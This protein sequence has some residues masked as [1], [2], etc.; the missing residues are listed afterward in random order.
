[1]LGGSAC[2]AVPPS[3]EVVTGKETPLSFSSNEK[4]VLKSGTKVL[5]PSSVATLS[6]GAKDGVA[7][8]ACSEK[9]SVKSEPLTGRELVM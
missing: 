7:P 8:N 2:A 6:F 4:V 3:F 1:M 9:W 5:V